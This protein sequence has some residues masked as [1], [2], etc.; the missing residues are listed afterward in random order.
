MVP[1]LLAL[2]LTAR[3]EGSNRYLE[4]ARLEYQ[5]LAYEQAVELLKAALSVPGTSAAEVAEIHLFRGLCTLQMG[6]EE[7]GRAGLRA[8][9]RADPSIE[10]P[11]LTSPKIRD[12]FDEE[13]RVQGRAP[14]SVDPP[15]VEAKPEVEP[16]PAVEP[17]LEPALVPVQGP[18]PAEAKAFEVRS[19]PPAVAPR[20]R[21]PAYATW[22]LAVVSAGIGGLCGYQAGNL[23]DQSAAAQYASDHVHLNQQA[24][25]KSRLANGFYGAA[26]G[27]GILGGAFFFAF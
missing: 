1:L 11:P 23:A 15:R 17:K 22:G 27:L 5:A 24:R 10:L 14:V 7:S 3:P 21:W 19:A 6:R 16:L 25:D 9:L 4:Q 20:V 12:I 13:A 8:A 26:L 2:A 18:A